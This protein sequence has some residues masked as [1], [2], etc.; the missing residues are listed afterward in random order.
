[1][2]DYL[3]YVLN[4]SHRLTKLN[5]SVVVSQMRVNTRFMSCVYLF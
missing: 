4:N 5:V 3:M 2:F 1:M